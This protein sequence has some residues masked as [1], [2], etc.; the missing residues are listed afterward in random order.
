MPAKLLVGQT[1]DRSADQTAG[2]IRP[3]KQ[4]LWPG[5]ASDQWMSLL[6]TS[7][8][9]SPGRWLPGTMRKT[10]CLSK[11]K[12]RL[13][14]ELSY[15]KLFSPG[16]LIRGL[17]YSSRIK[18]SDR[19]H[20]QGVLQL[21]CRYQRSYDVSLVQ[22]KYLGKYIIALNIM[23]KYKEQKSFGV[24]HLSHACPAMPVFVYSRASYACCH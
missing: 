2:S 8:P 13:L 23:W 20:Q 11:G 17:K 19:H 9:R 7:L 21:L 22:R 15:C 4:A 18:M 6:T 12:Q 14:A 1:Q 3:A 16:Q 10:R 24:T 5:R